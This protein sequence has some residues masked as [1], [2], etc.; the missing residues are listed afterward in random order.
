MVIHGLNKTTLLDFPG[1]VAA[2]I[3][4]GGCNFR[5]P[6]CQNGGLVLH[7]QTEPSIPEEEFFAFLRKRA[8][9]LTGVCISGGEPTLQPDL[10]D[11][12]LRIRALGYQVKLDTNGYRPDVMISLIEDGLVDYVAMDIKSSPAGYAR[13]TGIPDID[14]SKIQQSVYYLLK[15]HVPYEFRTTVVRDLHN[16]E[17]FV[18][19]GEWIRGCKHYYLQSYKDSEDVLVPGFSAYTTKELEQFVAILKPNIP[20]V[21]LRGVE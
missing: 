1:Q 4:T 13:A 11:F 19:I 7:P 9:I 18:K 8:G 16:S 10:R 14:L 15:E 20:N 21:S 3:F 2:S 6:F 12:I 5:C 17:D